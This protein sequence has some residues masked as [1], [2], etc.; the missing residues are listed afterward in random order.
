M[1]VSIGRGNADTIQQRCRFLGYKKQYL[2][3]CQ[4]YLPENSIE[5]YTDYVDHEEDIRNKIIAF[6]KNGGTDIKE[7]KKEFILSNILELTRS[8]VLVDRL[9]RFNMKSWEQFKIIDEN[10]SKYNKE[11]F[12][13]F[14]SKH[15]TN[16]LPSNNNHSNFKV[17]SLLC[18]DFLSRL[19]YNNIGT[20]Q[21]INTIIGIISW[22]IQNDKINSCYIVHMDNGK[23]RERS[24]RYT[25]NKHNVINLHA[26]RRVGY[27]GDMHE[28][29]EKLFTIQFHHI[30]PKNV[31]DGLKFNNFYTLFY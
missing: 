24:Y 12:N 31:P 14:I 3:L 20:V 28:F 17:N 26:G 9:E 19:K 30:K 29:N 5:A 23:I 1:P 18:L 16:P 27:R 6:Y 4:V 8:N 25:N 15:L 22:A 13:N 11:I 2:D 10:Y 21:K 7:L